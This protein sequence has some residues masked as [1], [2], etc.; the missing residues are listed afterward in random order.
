MF[1][2]TDYASDTPMEHRRLHIL[3]WSTIV[4]WNIFYVLIL[5]SIEF[6]LFSEMK[7]YNDWFVST[8][9]INTKRRYTNWRRSAKQHPRVEKI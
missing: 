4:Q 6:L 3:K 1:L 2:L 8:H 9:S 5:K 7:S